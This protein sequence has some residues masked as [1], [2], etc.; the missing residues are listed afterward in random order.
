MGKVKP[1][2]VAA[3]SD[4]E[5]YVIMRCWM[6]WMSL[7]ICILSELP[8]K[9]RDKTRSKRVTIESDEELFV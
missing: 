9:G 6:A 2:L 3:D 1:V 4:E 5:M 8:L 7:N